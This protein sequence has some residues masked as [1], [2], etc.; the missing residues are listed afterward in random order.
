MNAITPIISKAEQEARELAASILAGET[1]PYGKGGIYS[2]REWINAAQYLTDSD[3][4]SEVSYMMGQETI[5]DNGWWTQADY[6]N[7]DT[8]AG[9]WR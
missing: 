4:W 6:N 9:E 7:D 3:D 8:Y 5:A 2:A 1:Q